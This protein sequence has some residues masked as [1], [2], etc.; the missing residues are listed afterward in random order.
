MDIKISTFR[1]VPHA[2][3][4][5][6]GVLKEEKAEL[7]S[8]LQMKYSRVTQL[9][10]GSATGKNQVEYK[11][12]DTAEITSVD[13]RDATCKVSTATLTPPE[14]GSYRVRANFQGENNDAFL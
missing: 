9:V 2:Y 11:T 6:L 8:L 4:K 3:T 14:S 1:A 7:E 5:E 12:V 10:E 13:C